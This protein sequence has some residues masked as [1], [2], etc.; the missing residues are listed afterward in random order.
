MKLK[1]LVGSGDKVM[2]L[3]LPFLVAG[4]AANILWPAAFRLGLGTGGLIAA[5]VLLAIGVPLWLTSVAQILIYVPKKKLITTGPYALMLHPLFT[6]VALL[7]MPG[8]GLAFDS[9]VGVAIGAVLYVSTRLFAPAEER[10]LEKYFPAEYPAYR[11]KVLL[12][13]L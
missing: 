12:P 7:V 5:I 2:G 3:T 8:C 11:S 10:L 9:W 13:W 4:V 1:V 6:S